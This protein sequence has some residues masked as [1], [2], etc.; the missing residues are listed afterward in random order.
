MT[1]TDEWSVRT[2][3]GGIA[4]SSAGGQISYPIHYGHLTTAIPENW[5]VSE[6]NSAGWESPQ[7]KSIQAPSYT[8]GGEMREFRGCWLVIDEFNRAPIDL[9]LGEALTALGGS[10]RLRVPIDGG[11]A[12]LPLPQDF[13]IIGTLN[14]FDRNYLN[15]ISEALKR[16][17][18][19]IEVLPPTRAR[20]AEEQAIVLAKALASVAYLHPT[21][22]ITVNDDRS[23]AWRDVLRLAK[24][25]TGGF[26]ITWA[27]PTP[28]L[29]EAFDFTWNV[30]EVIRIYRQL[31]TAQAISLL[32]Q[33]L[34][35]GIVQSYSDVQQWVAAADQALCDDR[36][37]AAGA[38]ARRARG[39]D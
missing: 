24:V 30:F 11:S 25:D 7:R 19:F 33:M 12:E 36:R 29:Y 21:R 14:S 16:R 27:T 20:R 32:R 22:A 38:A 13:R 6:D 26:G 8:N 1:A 2:L 35:A 5:A 23:V 15:Q 4:P 17:F 10:G 39:V 3:I 9:A 31:G 18:S 34:I 37:S 28:V